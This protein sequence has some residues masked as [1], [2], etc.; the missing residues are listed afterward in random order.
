MDFA[1]MHRSMVSVC[2]TFL[3]TS[4][5]LS[6][7]VVPFAL[8]PATYEGSIHPTSSLPLQV[9]SILHF[10]HSCECVM[11]LRWFELV[12]SWW[13]MMVSPSLKCLFVIFISPL[14]KCLLKSFA[15]FYSVVWF[16]II[17]SVMFSVHTRTNTF[18]REIFCKHDCILLL[19]L[20]NTLY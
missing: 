9:V 5:L 15:H 4:T 19:Q 11:V 14:V 2:E 3:K 16:L 20:Y 1:E 18:Y 7:L 13:L 10:S 17:G 12:S 6:S 8:P